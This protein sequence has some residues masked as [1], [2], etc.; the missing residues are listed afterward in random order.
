MSD[1]EEQDKHSTSATQEEEKADGQT[2]KEAEADET[3]EII[4]SNEGNDTADKNEQVS[5]LQ[6]KVDALQKEKDELQQRVLRIQ[7]E[8]DNYKKRTLKEKEADRKYKSQDLIQELLPALDNF[9]RALQVEKT[10]ENAGLIDG[11]TMVYNQVKEAI[12]SQGVEEIDTVGEEFDPNL[13]HAVM[14]VED[15]EK[16]SNTIVEELQKGY[17]LKDRVIRPAMVKVNK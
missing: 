15:E 12:V 9:E 5:E 13:H 10:D 2:V 14:Q 17:K 7:A 1:V 11:I 6:S 16:S 3:I 8:F 4:D